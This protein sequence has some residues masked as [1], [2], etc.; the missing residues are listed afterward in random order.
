MSL[1]IA[2]SPVAKK[3]ITSITLCD[4]VVARLS[5][6]AVKDM[7]DAIVRLAQDDAPPEMDEKGNNKNAKLSLA[8]WIIKNAESKPKGECRA[9]FK[10]IMETLRAETMVNEKLYPAG[11]L[12]HVID[13]K[14]GI[15]GGAVL[16]RPTEFSEIEIGPTMFLYHVPNFYA[17]T[18]DP[19]LPLP[20]QQ[21]AEGNLDLAIQRHLTRMATSNH[22]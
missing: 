3:R 1:D 10:P 12:W 8:K 18:V 7:R 19:N 14:K 4:D 16:K 2:E 15:D 21:Q 11:V 22:S 13:D 9:L 17:H 6:A 20:Q 5:Y